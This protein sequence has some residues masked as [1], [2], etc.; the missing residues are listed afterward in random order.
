MLSIIGLVLSL[1]MKLCQIIIE[2]TN[3]IRVAIATLSKYGVRSINFFA[4][5]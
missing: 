4:L 2:L 1:R 5:A 3:T